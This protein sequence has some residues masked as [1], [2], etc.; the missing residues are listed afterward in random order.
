MQT[1]NRRL[2]LPALAISL[3]LSVALGAVVCYVVGCA[4]TPPAAPTKARVVT[5]EEKVCLRFAELKNRGDA[6]AN[7]LLG[8]PP[9]VPAD[10][11]T[12]AEG[13]RLDTEVFLRRDYRITD[14]RPEGTDGR[15][16]ALVVEGN[17]MSEPMRVG[18]DGVGTRQIVNPDLIV[19]VRDGKLYGVLSQLHQDPN[20]RPLTPREAETLRRAFGA[21]EP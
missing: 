13:Q 3:F 21:E 7:E 19:E 14:V 6:S 1:T 15:L 2:V 17:L 11:V 18:S 9:V 12:E 4:P 20:R 8:A 5:P 16:F 10:P